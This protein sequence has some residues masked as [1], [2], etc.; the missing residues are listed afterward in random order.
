MIHSD[1][2]ETKTGLWLHS[3]PAT[4]LFENSKKSYIEYRKIFNILI[5]TKKKYIQEMQQ[6]KR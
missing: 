1:N 2:R 3:G 6:K 5:E 4:H